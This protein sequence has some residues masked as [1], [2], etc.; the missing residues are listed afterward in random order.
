MNLILAGNEVSGC[1]CIHLANAMRAT[2]QSVRRRTFSY[3]ARVRTCLVKRVLE[4][5]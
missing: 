5:R 4:G 1:V 2:Y 3:A